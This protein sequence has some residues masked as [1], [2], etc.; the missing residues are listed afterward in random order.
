MRLKALGHRAGTIRGAGPYLHT[1]PDLPGVCDYYA[2]LYAQSICWAYLKVCLGEDA[3][4]GKA[5]EQSAESGLMT[6]AIVDPCGIAYGVCEVGC[7]LCSCRLQLWRQDA[8]DE[9]MC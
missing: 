4:L 2:A 6:R 8:S 7:Q 1:K 3:K 5:A 9:L